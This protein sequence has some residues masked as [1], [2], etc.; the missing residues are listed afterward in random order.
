MSR[1]EFEAIVWEWKAESGGTI[2][3]Q[4]RRLG[5]SC[6]WSRERFTMGD[7]D[8]PDDKMAEAVVK[9]FVQMYEEGLI[10]RDKRLVNWDPHF[11]TAISDLEVETKTVDGH[12]WHLKYPLAEGVSYEHPLVDDEGEITGYENRDYIIVATSRPETMLGD[13]APIQKKGQGR[14]KLRRL[15]ILMI[16]RLVNA[17]GIHPFLFWIPAHIFSPYLLSRRPITVN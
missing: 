17:Q 1:E 15:M 16:M 14:L 13:T 12:Y 5:A 7:P 6:D 8:N 3:K 4:L 10:Y 11:Q 9:V 2:V